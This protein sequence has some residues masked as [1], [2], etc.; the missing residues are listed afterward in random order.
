VF[1]LP[2]T[3]DIAE[4]EVHIFDRWGRVVFHSLDPNFEWDGNV[5]GKILS[6]R[7]YNYRID[8]KTTGHEKMVL[9]GS[10]TVL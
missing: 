10:I 3:K 8:L 5:N 4:F 1:K 7:V 6:G 9:S 2:T